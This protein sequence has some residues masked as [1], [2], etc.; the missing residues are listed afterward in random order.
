MKGACNQGINREGLVSN[1]KL[2]SCRYDYYTCLYLCCSW[3]SILLSGTFIW[4]VFSSIPA[5]MKNSNHVICL[6]NPDNETFSCWLR[7]WGYTTSSWYQRA[8]STGLRWINL[9]GEGEIM[10]QC[11]LVA[12]PMGVSTM[13]DNRAKRIVASAR[14]LFSRPM[15]LPHP[16]VFPAVFSPI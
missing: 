7:S 5:A 1:W 11:S 16:E 6:Y 4:G 2:S 14:L 8:L 15:P 3:I 10:P 12:S 13:L 9:A